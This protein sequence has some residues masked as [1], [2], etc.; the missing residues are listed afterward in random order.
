MAPLFSSKSKASNRIILSEN[1]KLIT[2]EQKSAEVFNNYFNSI[3]EELNIP[4][5][6]NLLNDASLFDDPIIAAIHK[7]KRHPS[8]LKIKEQLKKSDLF[9]FYHVNPDK[10]L[11]II[12]NIDS[13]KATQHGDI[14]VRM[15]K[16]N[17]FIF[18]KVLSEIFNFYIDNNTFSNGLKKANINPIHKKDDPFDKTNYRPISILPVLSKPFERCLYDQIDEYIDTVLSKAQCGF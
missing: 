5:D 13:K 2:N 7:Y 12:E 4:I 18:S 8:I 1:E 9:S 11:K 17:K 16:E 14:P 10:M 15:I 3:I 6:Q